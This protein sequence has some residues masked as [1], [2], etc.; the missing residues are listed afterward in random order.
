MQDLAAPH[1]D[2]SPLIPLPNEYGRSYTGQASD[3]NHV[4]K[5]KVID[6]PG[7]TGDVLSSHYAMADGPALVWKLPTLITA[8]AF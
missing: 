5:L 8:G 2:V 7:E 4:L 1:I 3:L 6:F